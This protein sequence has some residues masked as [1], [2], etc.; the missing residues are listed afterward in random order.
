MDFTEAQAA[1]TIGEYEDGDRRAAA[2]FQAK[3]GGPPPDFPLHVLAYLGDDGDASR[4]L[5]YVHFT[6]HQGA[7]FGGGACVDARV[8]KRASAAERALVAQRGGAY[9]ATLSWAVRHLA[10]RADA[11]FG[12]C[13]DPSALRTDLRAGFERT[14]HPHLLAYWTRPLP[15]ERKAALIATAHAVGPF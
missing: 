11:I 9:F 6:A 12:Y 5:C 4:L 10:T 7:L 2:L 13:G 14:A 8:L 15:D 3:F 1:L